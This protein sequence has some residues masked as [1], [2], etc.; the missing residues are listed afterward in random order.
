MSATDQQM[1]VA[2]LRRI[3]CNLGGSGDGGAVGDAVDLPGVSL[4]GLAAYLRTD[5]EA[6]E[7]LVRMANERRRLAAVES[8]H[9]AAMLKVICAVACIAAAVFALWWITG[10]TVVG[11]VLFNRAAERSRTSI[12]LLT[13]GSD[14]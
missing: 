13:A 1:E 14:G 4:D 9:N 7:R 12:G 6:T 2:A 8:M 11:V 3:D 5:L 10:V